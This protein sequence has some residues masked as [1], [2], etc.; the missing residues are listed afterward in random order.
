MLSIEEIP[1]QTPEEAELLAGIVGEEEITWMA[2][3]ES[4]EMASFKVDAGT[5]DLKIQEDVS[6]EIV[7][8]LAILCVKN[9][10]GGVVAVGMEGSEVAHVYTY[11]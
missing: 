4:V 6:P 8:H 1:G 2:L 7:A 9:T 11:L 5:F 10:C 3:P